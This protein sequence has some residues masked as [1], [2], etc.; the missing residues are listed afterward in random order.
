MDLLNVVLKRERQQRR[1]PASSSPHTAS[2]PSPDQTT[3]DPHVDVIVI[4]AGWA[5]LGAARVLHAHGLQ[6]LVLEAKDHVG[7]RSRTVLLQDDQKKHAAIPVELGSEWI[8]GTSER[9]NPIYRLARHYHARLHS[10]GHQDDGV[11]S[12]TGSDGSRPIPPKELERAYRRLMKH[13]WLESVRRYR[14]SIDRDVS[15]RR[16]TDLSM[17]RR[18]GPDRDMLEYLLHANIVTE[19][20]ASLE[21]ISA[22]WWD[23][24]WNMDGEE[25]I[26]ADG[27]SALVER[28]AAALGASV[29]R[30]A[31]VTAVDWRDPESVRVTYG[32]GSGDA[33]VTAR[34][35]IVTVPLGVLQSR[36][37]QFTPSLPEW[38]QASIDRLGVSL[39][40]KVVLQ[41]DR[42][43]VLP[44]PKE[45]EWLEK[46]AA[47]Q[48]HWTEFYNYQS[49]TGA[50]VLVA[51]VAGRE[52]ARIEQLSDEDVLAE[53]LA[54]L[55][56]MMNTDIPDPAAFLVTRWSQD[57]FARGSYTHY[58][59]G[60]DP[61]D[62]KNL[63]A[64]L[65]NRIYFAG[66]ACHLKYP[67]TTHG[68]LLTGL[69]VGRKVTAT[70]T[71]KR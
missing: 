66:E 9:Y 29:R 8:H 38:K 42:N 31:A 41:W 52:A 15:L 1:K 17:N 50:N 47:R 69:D 35:V 22:W 6:V 55:R 59:P 23:S 57:P 24:D 53:V 44:W 19:Y 51:F 46:I 48:D 58:R 36:A 49:I 18:S 11:W 21:D 68:A 28:F 34:C 60:S 71:A 33:V 25:A 62:R 26:L 13:G 56:E 16:A 14:D 63:Q 67:S 37:I 54:S 12:T 45:Y 10:T 3:H 65:D 4:G 40:N 2:S 64:N 70:L 61:D 20:A 30:E 5:G 27:Y 7:G 32:Q 43:Q 39:L